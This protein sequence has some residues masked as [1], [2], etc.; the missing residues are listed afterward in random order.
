[1]NILWQIFVEDI[2]RYFLN[3]WW[4]IFASPMEEGTP[5]APLDT[6]TVVNAGQ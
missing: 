4:Q 1:M 3:I 2:W 5:T 6:G